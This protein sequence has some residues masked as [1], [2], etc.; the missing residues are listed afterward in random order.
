MYLG[1][2]LKHF[3]FKIDNYFF[4]S[5]VQMIYYFLS[6]SFI[7]FFDKVLKFIPEQFD[8]MLSFQ[9]LIWSMLGFRGLYTQNEYGFFVGYTMITFYTYEMLF[10]KVKKSVLLHHL[11]AIFVAFYTYYILGIVYVKRI[12]VCNHITFA[13]MISSVL[14]NNRI[15]VKNYYPKYHKKFSQLYT[16]TFLISKSIGIICYYIYLLFFDKDIFDIYVYTLLGLYFLIH[17]TQI[18]FMNILLSRY[19][20]SFQKLLSFEN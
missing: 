5:I 13:S 9:Y 15:I 20:Y 16:I 4:N 8:I 3:V 19:D 6:L 17:F 14:S 7:I 10:Y 11:I 12:H 1:Y 2:V 18:Y